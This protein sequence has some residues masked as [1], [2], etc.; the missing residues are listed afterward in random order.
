MLLH[1]VSLKYN[2]Y[3]E[4]IFYINLPVHVFF[5]CVPQSGCT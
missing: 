1:R 5:K 4:I 3:H 2:T